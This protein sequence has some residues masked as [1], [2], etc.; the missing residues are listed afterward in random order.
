MQVTE[1]KTVAIIG[2]MYVTI[3]CAKGSINKTIAGI[4]GLSLAVALRSKGKSGVQTNKT[5]TL[6]T[7]EIGYTVTVFDRNAYDKTGYEPEGEDALAASVD[8][9]KIVSTL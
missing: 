8:L 5:E 6:I 2:G 9:N 3:G 7:S 1:K 4:F